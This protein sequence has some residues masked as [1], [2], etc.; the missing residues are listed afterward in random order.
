MVHEKAHGASQHTANSESSVLTLLPCRL[1][2]SSSQMLVLHL[3]STRVGT[4]NL[5]TMPCSKLHLDS[6][7]RMISKTL[8]LCSASFT[9]ARCQ[10]ILPCQLP[11]VYLVVVGETWKEKQHLP[12]VSCCSC[13]QETTSFNVW[14]H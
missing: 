1:V 13:H 4:Y 9:T 8:K 14:L 3:E 2:V 5:F 7:L 12:V 6:Q 10:G 11:A